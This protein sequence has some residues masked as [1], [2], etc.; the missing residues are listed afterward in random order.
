MT[1]GWI[2]AIGAGAIFRNSLWSFRVSGIPGRLLSF[3]GKLPKRRRGSRDA[4]NVG[5]FVFGLIV[6]MIEAHE[7]SN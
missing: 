1:P 5:R 2:D 4:L 7:N 3:L 6:T